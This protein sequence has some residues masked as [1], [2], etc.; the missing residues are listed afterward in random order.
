VKGRETL[1]L[2]LFPDLLPGGDQAVVQRLTRRYRGSILTVAL[3]L[4]GALG[5]AGTSQNLASERYVIA[6][7]AVFVPGPPETAGGG[8]TSGLWSTDGRYLLLTHSRPFGVPA[9]PGPEAG[10]TRFSV[11]DQSLRRQRELWRASVPARQVRATAWFPGVP[12]ALARVLLP[13]D[14]G[15]PPETRPQEALVRLDART[16]TARVLGPLP[17]N[18]ILAVSPSA[19]LAA[20]W[21]GRETELRALR[22]DGSWGPAIRLPEGVGLSPVWHTDGLRLLGW[23]R[24][25]APP[26]A[27]GQRGK[28]EPVTIDPANGRIAPGPPDSLRPTDSPQRA[29]L[30]IGIRKAPGSLREGSGQEM[31]QTLWLVATGDSPHPRGLIAAD[32]DLG[33]LSPRGD[34]VLVVT[35]G[36]ATVVPIQRWERA[37]FTEARSAAIRARLMSQGMQ[38]A[39]AA[40]MYSQDYDKRLP[41]AADPITQLLMP[42]TGDTRLF[43]GFVYTFVGGPLRDVQE[44]AKAVLGY[45]QGADG[46]AVVYVDGHVKWEPR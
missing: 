27:V 45:V 3:L 28:A 21:A 25:P 46:R 14:P 4:G 37:V 39:K 11:W 23:K 32:A 2:I 29:P 22:P 10:E 41:G 5:T 7:D 8:V 18:A 34:A 40:L 19:P 24:E 43:D 1:R 13:D 36:A 30:P 44:P 16:G 6:G 17:S 35:D 20:V 31:V 38:L 9:M 33:V 26:G 12:V 15:L 42:Y